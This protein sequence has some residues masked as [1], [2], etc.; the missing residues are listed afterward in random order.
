MTIHKGM[1]NV[2]QRGVYRHGAHAPN[3]QVVH[4]TK[5]SFCSRCVPRDEGDE[6]NQIKI[7]SSRWSSLVFNVDIFKLST[8]RGRKCSETVSKSL[9][10]LDR[11][12]ETWRTRSR[13]EVAL[14]VWLASVLSHDWPFVARGDAF[15]CAFASMHSCPHPLYQW[16]E[17]ERSTQAQTL[18]L[19]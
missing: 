17:S 10:I 12:S 5:A 7:A 19:P 16:S 18:S 1:N 13:V 3:C 4:R 2:I 6:S 11:A 15:N 8:N 14:F 9:S